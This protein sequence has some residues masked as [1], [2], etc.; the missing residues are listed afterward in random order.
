MKFSNLARPPAADESEEP[1]PYSCSKLAEPAI[2]IA[3]AR[4]AEETICRVH[5]GWFTHLN[6][7][8]KVYL[9]AVGRMYFRHAKR[10]SEGLKPL[11][12][13]KAM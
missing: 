12:Y 10:P 5:N 1:L 4:A 8:G 2:T 11:R 3:E 9:C 7:D 13:P 6:T